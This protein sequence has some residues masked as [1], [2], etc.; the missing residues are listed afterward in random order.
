VDLEEEAVRPG[1]DGGAR[2]RLGVAG[3]AAALAAL[4]AAGA[5]E[6]QRVGDVVDHRDPILVH[7]GEAAHV[8]H[9]VM[10]AEG[11]AA[12]GD[13]HPVVARRARLVDDPPHAL[14]DAAVQLSPARAEALLASV[15]ALHR[16][17]R[18]DFA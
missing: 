11:G 1:G 14:S 7:H 16:A 5:G 2:Q 4:P 6:L 17:L 15:L 12:L 10:V 3:E 8:D 13:R 9:Q 18:E